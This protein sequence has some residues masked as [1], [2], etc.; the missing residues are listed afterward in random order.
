M[1]TLKAKGLI[2]IF[3][4]LVL[5]AIIAGCGKRVYTKPGMTQ[6]DWNKDYFECEMQCT[7]YASGFGGGKSYSM[8]SAAG[9]GAAM[10][11]IAAECIPR[12]IEA[13]GWTLQKQ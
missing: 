13:R 11:M 9:S 8:G 1:K 3:L 5:A 2:V 6:A 4:S 7:Q 12:C 10:G